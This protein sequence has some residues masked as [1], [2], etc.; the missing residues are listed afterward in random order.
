MVCALLGTPEIV[1]L[2]PTGEQPTY[3]NLAAS[4]EWWW[5]NTVIPLEDAFADEIETQ[6][7][8]AF[9]LDRHEY[10][11]T[12]DRSQ[13]PALQEDEIAKH[14]M[15]REDYRAGV[16]DL[17]T[18]TVQL[19]GEAVED[20]RGVYHPSAAAEGS[21]GDSTK[22]ADI[23]NE[24]DWVRD[25]G[26]FQRY[27]G[28]ERAEMLQG[29]P[30]RENVPIA[31]SHLTDDSSEAA[32]AHRR[33]MQLVRQH[34]LK[35]IEN[36]L[37]NTQAHR[38]ALIRRRNKVLPHHTKLIR[39][40]DKEL[41]EAD[42]QIMQYHIDSENGINAIKEEVRTV[43]QPNGDPHLVQAKLNSRFT[44]SEEAILREG[45]EEFSRI[46]H[47]SDIGH[48]FVH[49]EKS[50]ETS[51]DPATGIL[52]WNP[53]TGK[54][55]VI[56]ELGHW[57]EAQKTKDSVSAVD[58]LLRRTAGNPPRPL[59]EKYP[60][61]GYTT[62]LYL[63]DEFAEAYIGRFYRKANGKIFATE[64]TAHGLEMLYD[65]PH[66]LIQADPEHF[67][68]IYNILRGRL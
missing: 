38:A 2:L 31:T 59:K 13:V 20:M 19:G 21:S 18:A 67:S 51:F 50:K 61:S 54:V 15:V 16:I 62:E 60:K 47:R 33:L 4:M 40:I 14:Q 66:L 1:A 34:D 52:K 64:L 35:G 12:W 28:T 23:F 39:S 32:Q 63:P 49:T 26:R 8:P 68:F 22:A 3:Q 7:F 48:S 9:G 29:E 56:H 55:G 46:V 30:A 58:L 27:V 45:Y 65:R 44:A 36:R 17:F 10:R 57:L 37:A 11:L 41:L 25:K 6:F 24:S 42:V 43:L 5:N 53:Q